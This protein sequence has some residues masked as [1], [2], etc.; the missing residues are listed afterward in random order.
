MAKKKV[1][2]QSQIG[3]S[4]FAAVAAKATAAGAPKDGAYFAEGG[5]VI[6]RT[7]VTTVV[8]KT[9]YYR[10]LELLGT[11]Q[12]ITT[13]NDVVIYI[14]ENGPI[15]ALNPGELSFALLSGTPAAV[16]AEDADEPDDTDDEDDEPAPKK[17]AKKKAVVE[18]DEDDED[19]EPAPKKKG[20][21][22]VEEDDEDDE[23]APKKRGKKVVE[24][25]DDEDDDDDTDSSDDDDDDDDEDDEPAPKKRGKKVVEDDEDDEPAPK[26][27]GKPARASD[28]D[29]EEEMF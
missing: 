3:L 2:A 12:E 17:T 5:L 21:K 16:E 13:K 18:A 23:P 7:S 25:D 4:V 10:T 1:E 20:K 6:P 14:T 8:G 28:D 11:I 22:V 27:K 29:D 9:I 26:K 19:D 15:I 24:E